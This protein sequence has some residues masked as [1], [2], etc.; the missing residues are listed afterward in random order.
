MRSPRSPPQKKATSKKTISKPAPVIPLDRTPLAVAG[1]YDQDVQRVVD[2]SRKIVDRDGLIRKAIRDLVSIICKDYQVEEMRLVTAGQ[3]NVFCFNTH[4][5][6]LIGTD[7]QRICAL[8]KSPERKIKG[9]PC[10]LPKCFGSHLEVSI[11]NLNF[12]HSGDSFQSI[13]YESPHRA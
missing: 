13:C 5:V 10:F 12:G 4:Y 7:A 3:S 2:S 11:C 8:R 1:P 9:F 6:L